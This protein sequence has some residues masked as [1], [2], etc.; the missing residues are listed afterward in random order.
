[1]KKTILASVI[2]LLIS[3]TVIASDATP[4]NQELWDL[5]QKQQQ[6]INQLKKQL[7]TTEQDIADNADAVEEVKMSATQSSGGKTKV[8][9]Y[10]ELHYANLDGK[11]D[12]IDFHR[13]VLFFDHEFNDQ[14]RFYSEL[15]LEHAFSADGEVGEVE[16]EQAFLEYDF[17]QNH[18]LL[19]GVYLVPIGLINETHEPPTFYGVERNS[20]EKNIIPATWWEAGVGLNGAFSQG[21][22]YDFMLSSGLNV[23]TSGKNAFKIRKGRQKVAEAIGENGALTARIRY[24][25]LQGL[26]LGIAGQYQDDITQ[27]VNEISA[28]LLEAHVSYQYQGFGLKALYA[29]WWLD[30][31]KNGI[32]PELIGRDKQEGGYIEPSYKLNLHHDMAVGFFARY[33]QWNN[34]AGRNGGNDSKQKMIGMNFWLHPDVVVKADYQWQNNQAGNHDGFNLGIGYQF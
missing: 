24:T 19:G 14:L 8:G 34:E 12:K 5:I 28:V 20:V 11:K 6:T 30:N 26:E 27:G 22:K 15:E 17:T 3:Q 7:H 21:L 4:T 25:G 33:E 13:F 2:G 1:M 29:K 10:G 23:P 16:L 31:G 9:G 18:H 32:N